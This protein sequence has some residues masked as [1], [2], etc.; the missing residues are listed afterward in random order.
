MALLGPEAEALRDRYRRAGY[1]SSVLTARGGQFRVC[2]GQFPS[3][4]D[5]I[6]L[7]NKEHK[8]TYTVSI[9][10]TPEGF[11]PLL[12]FL[13]V[14]KANEGDMCEIYEGTMPRTHLEN[15]LQT[16]LANLIA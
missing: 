15:Q 12:A 7:R 1:R 5:A 16:H 3:R 14:I 10:V 4:D 6:R 11:K 9:S 13:A 2:V 8:N